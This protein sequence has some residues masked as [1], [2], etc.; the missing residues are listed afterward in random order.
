MT[1]NLDAIYTK[2]QQTIYRRCV[3][4]DWFM[5]INHGAKRSGKT[6][7][8]NDLFLQE[9]IRV[10]EMAT[11][12]G[13][14]KPMYIVS[15]ATLGTIQNNILTELTNKY[16]IQFS[17]DKH[18]NFTLFGVYCVQAGHSTIAH[19][20]KIRGMTAFGAYVNEGT[21]ANEEVFDEI[22]SRCSGEGARILVDT[23]PDHP[24]HWL[25]KDYIESDAE[26][27]ISYSFQLDDN[28]FLS[29]RYRKNMIETTPSGMFTD[30][31]IY[32]RWVSGD[33]VV[34]ADFNK[35]KHTVTK[36]DLTEIKMVRYFCGVDW[37]YEHFGA[38]V[39]VGVDADG[40]YYVVEE[41][42]HQ[43]YD[44]EHDWVPIAKEII[45]R[46]GNIPFYCDSAR[47]EY[48]KKFKDKKIHA[49]FASKKVM[50]G[51]E[52]VAT[53]IKSDQFYIN[54]DECPRFKDEIYKYVWHKTK[55]EPVEE[56]DD[57]LDA[58]RYALLS[59]KL[60]NSKKPKTEELN[61][62]K[63]LLR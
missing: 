9:L 8:N 44:V 36:D 24:E 47:P 39:V 43:H 22:K 12:Q 15:G 59:D 2:K 63:S 45:S 30:R 49:K 32:G 55:D 40:N 56:F 25:L 33:G 54:Y 46:Y 53:L 48:V 37:G 35:D 17:F 1:V 52:T 5:L 41:H 42:A 57:V 19:L 3:N 10:K 4:D 62:L 27:I 34:Y 50:L 14:E 28:T 20:D 60:V 26:G 61:A 38:I 13:I 11:K 31:N 58:I 23:N 6:V 29:E 16:G 18:N 7:L 21:L 51:I